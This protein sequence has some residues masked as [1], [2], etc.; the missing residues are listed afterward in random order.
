MKILVTGGAG[1][2]GSILCEVLLN[3]GYEVTVVDN[4]YYS[5]QRS[6]FHLC[7]NTNFQFIYGDAGDPKLMTPL[8][9]KADVI[10]PLAA[11]VGMPACAVNVN[12]AWYTNY[13]TIQMLNGIREDKPVIFPTTNSGYGTQSGEVFCTEETPLEPISL[14]AQTKVNAEKILLETKNA[15]TLRLATVFGMSPRMRSDLIVNDFTLKAVTDGNII[16]Y[17]KDYKRNFVHI[18]DVADCFVHCIKNYNKMKGEAYNVGLDIANISKQDLAEEI[19]KQVPDFD[20]TYKE[21]GTDP[22]QRNYIVSNEKLKKAGFEAK[23]SLDDGIKELIKGYKM[24]G[25][26]SLKNI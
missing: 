17:E 5:S 20:I 10:L 14:Y 21:V 26:N 19:K 13:D 8:V 18:R 2:L 3:E 23:R 11:I 7:S 15:I 25:R 12:L 6:L 24:L 16:I 9:S 22:D 1:Y 4:L